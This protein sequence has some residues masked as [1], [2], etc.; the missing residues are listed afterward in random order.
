MNNEDLIR[1]GFK[2]V[3]HF[4]VMDSLTYSLGRNR[5]LSAGCVGSPNEFLCI[6]EAE[7]ETRITDLVCLHNWDYDKELTIE[8]VEGL[9]KLILGN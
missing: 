6:Y 8:K 4:T 5:F 2:K 9:I 3:D 1:I 7:D